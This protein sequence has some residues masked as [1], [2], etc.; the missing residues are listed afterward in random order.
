MP[1][2][3]LYSRIS[4]KFFILKTGTVRLAQNTFQYKDKLIHMKTHTR[5]SRPYQLSNKFDNQNILG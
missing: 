3:A 2:E 1:L 4:L 5:T